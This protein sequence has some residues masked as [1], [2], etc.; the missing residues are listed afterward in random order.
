[1]RGERVSDRRAAGAGVAKRPSALLDVRRDLRRETRL[2]DAGGSGHD[3]DAT[4]T[5]TSLSPR[6]TQPPHL[7]LARDER[8]V[9]IE[10]ERQHAR[11]P[12]VSAGWGR[13]RRRL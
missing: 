11:H 2:A 5:A 7:V 8:C 10:L 4:R 13:R 9:D 6:A 1:M 3:D 12:T